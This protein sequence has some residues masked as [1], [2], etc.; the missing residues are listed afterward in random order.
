MST[1]DEDLEKKIVEILKHRE[2]CL[3]DGYCHYSTD[4]DKILSRI[5]NEIVGV[6][7]MQVRDIMKNGGDCPHCG[8]MSQKLK[9]KWRV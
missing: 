8:A 7:K 1:Y 4:E 9:G 6:A 2:D 3:S 5:A